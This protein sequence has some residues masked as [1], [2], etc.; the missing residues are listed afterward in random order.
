MEN[1]MLIKNPTKKIIV[2]IALLLAI[3]ALGYFGYQYLFYRED[4][5][6]ISEFKLNSAMEITEAQ[7]VMFYLDKASYM[8]S[9][10]TDKKIDIV[11]WCYI[12]GQNSN[13]TDI[14][15][16]LKEKDTK[17]CFKLPTTMQKRA[18]V[19][20]CFHDGWNYD[21]SG[22]SVSVSGNRFHL[23]GKQYEVWLLYCT[24][25]K[26]YLVNTGQCLTAESEK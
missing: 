6:G 2:S 20:A 22:F 7:R 3:V 9:S 15:V 19:T 5:N 24:G 25:E 21:N 23:Q 26:K 18:D 11:G 4:E 10:P 17:Y 16:L 13:N 12:K 14:K 8:V 1:K